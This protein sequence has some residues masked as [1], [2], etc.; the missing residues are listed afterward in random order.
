MKPLARLQQG[1]QAFSGPA[2]EGIREAPS[3]SAAAP[4]VL[5]FSINGADTKKTAAG[6]QTRIFHFAN[7]FLRQFRHIAST[8]RRGGRALPRCVQP[9]GA[10]R[11]AASLPATTQARRWAAVWCVYLREMMEHS[12]PGCEG[13][14]AS[15]PVI[16]RYCGKMPV[17]FPIPNRRD[18]PW[19]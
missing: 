16:C 13:R 2:N 7:F 17:A 10:V 5:G 9:V 8:G 4:W 11:S 6:C 18:A 3:S 19:P 15:P 1:T 12:R 14:L